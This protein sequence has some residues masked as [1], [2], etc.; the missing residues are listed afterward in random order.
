MVPNAGMH[1][2]VV[3]LFIFQAKPPS[4][5]GI[6]LEPEHDLLMFSIRT[7][8]PIDRL[9]EEG[10]DQLADLDLYV[11]SLVTLIQRQVVV[12]L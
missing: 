2:R 3:T 6:N 7:K 11:S 9:K 5:T 12:E 10:V 4:P 8:V 1:R